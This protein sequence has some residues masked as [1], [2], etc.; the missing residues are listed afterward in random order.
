MND[1]QSPD[2]K[3]RRRWIT[4]GEII[5]L[6]ALAISGLG[7]WNSWRSDNDKPAPPPAEQ[8]RAIPIAFR[9]QVEDE[10]KAMV[11]SPVE[12][13]HA[14]ESL[15]VT[16]AGKPVI[17]AGSDGR[18]SASEV[19][20]LVEAGKEKRPG[21]LTARI[22]ARYIEA[23]ALKQGGGRYRISYRWDEGGLF[24]GKRLRLTGLSHG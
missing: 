17:S 19:E 7:L 16:V 20:R 11:V 4:L 21:T 1:S 18:I 2:A 12:T 14:L 22:D 8:R 6:A 24:G 5:G 13:G 23:G 3:A 9:G 15:T 10:G